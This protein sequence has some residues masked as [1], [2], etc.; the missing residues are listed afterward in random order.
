[1]ASRHLFLCCKHASNHNG[2]A[3]AAVLLYIS[4]RIQQGDFAL[5]NYFTALV[6]AATMLLITGCEEKSDSSG[7]GSDS[8]P[9]LTAATLGEQ[10][11]LPVSEYLLVTPY[12]SANRTNGEK[13]ARV[14][15][16]CHS[17]DEGGPNMIGPALHG[18]FGS[19]AG[20]SAG[21]DYSPALQAVEFIWTPR[22]LDAWL[23]RPGGFLPGNRM[24]F[25]GV[26]RQ[27]DRDDLIA[28]LLDVTA[29]G[30]GS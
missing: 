24:S 5:G 4:Y 13:L 19:A 28:F 11:V 25:P 17:L 18:F 20:S 15:R 29:T 30:D 27:S 12:S 21:Y 7:P 26:L 10:T 16:A 1:M 3:F 22:A 2:E 6:A 8:L 23:A 14:C 9:S